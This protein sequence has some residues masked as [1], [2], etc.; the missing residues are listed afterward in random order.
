M[1]IPL[2]TWTAPRVESP[3]ETVASAEARSDLEQVARSSVLETRSVFM[4]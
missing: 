3:R 4:N 1:R 2:R